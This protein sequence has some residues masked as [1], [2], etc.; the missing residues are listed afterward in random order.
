MGRKTDR[1]FQRNCFVC[2]EPMTLREEGWPILECVHCE[3]FENGT[4]KGRH[5]LAPVP[6]E[7]LGE[8][9]KFIDHSKI[10]LPSPDMTP[11]AIHLGQPAGC[12]A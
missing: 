4:W 9:V 7:W 3:V 8:F 10:H 12:Q 6:F 11:Q 5:T 2:D 1:I